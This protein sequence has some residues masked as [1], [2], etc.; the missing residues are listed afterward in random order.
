MSSSALL[1]EFK[2][3]ELPALREKCF[4]LV[5]ILVTTFP[6]VALLSPGHFVE[7]LHG[8]LLGD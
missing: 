1:S 7:L 6:S 5:E 4:R 8:C 3:S 2:M